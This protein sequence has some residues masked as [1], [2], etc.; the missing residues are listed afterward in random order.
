[1]RN[2]KGK[3]FWMPFLLKFQKGQMLIDAAR[4][5]DQFIRYPVVAAENDE[6]FS[7][8]Q[9]KK[10]E[11]TLLESISP[12][13]DGIITDDT[14]RKIMFI[15]AASTEDD[16]KDNSVKMTDEAIETAVDTYFPNSSQEHWKGE[17]RF[18]GERILFLQMINDP[19]YACLVQGWRCELLILELCD[20]STVEKSLTAE[21]WAVINKNSEKMLMGEDLQHSWR[22]VFFAPFAL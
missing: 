19:K 14:T 15:M 20:D 17:Y 7:L 21:E 13:W 18:L 5:E 9:I 3:N 8:P 6:V 22:N 10:G 11:S 4:E 1:M 2:M 12:L 16:L